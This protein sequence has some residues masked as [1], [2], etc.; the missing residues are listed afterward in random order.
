M[1]GGASPCRCP[2]RTCPPRD[3]P[4]SDQR[5][6]GP[7]PLACALSSPRTST[8]TSTVRSPPRWT[9]PCSPWPRPGRARCG[10]GGV[11][12]V[13]GTPGAEFHPGLYTRFADLIIRKGVHPEYDSY[14]GFAD[15]GGGL[16]G[17]A[18]YL[19]ANGIEAVDVVG[20]ATDYCVKATAIDAVKAGFRTRV[21]A[22]ACA[23]VAKATI[24][25][26]LAEMAAAG[27]TIV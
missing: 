6:D 19:K 15:D 25:A 3:H 14:S 1:T 17:L 10:F 13:E 11:H 22:H 23:G 27:V 18:G 2:A 16:T 5:A 24:T 4:A 26:A 9:C 12:C 7:R 8:P 20:I 21:L